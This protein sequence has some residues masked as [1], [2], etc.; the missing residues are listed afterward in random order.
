MELKNERYNGI[1][2]LRGISMILILVMHVLENLTYLNDVKN[3]ELVMARFG[4]L[5]SLFLM[6]SAF[7]CCCGYYQK[8]INGGMKEI[9]LFYSKRFKKIFPF[10]AFLTVIDVLLNF[11]KSA[12]IEGY[13]NITLIFG[14][15]PHENITTIGVG[16]TLGVIFIFYLLFPFFVYLIKNNYRLIIALFVTLIYTFV[17]AD[18]FQLGKVDFLF[19]AP[20]FV[21]GCCIYKIRQYII[22]YFKRL[23]VLLMIILLTML[24]YKYTLYRQYTRIVLFTFMLI[25]GIIVKNMTILDNKLMTFLSSISLEVY[26]SHMMI[27]RLIQKLGLEM[28]TSNPYINYI[29]ATCLTIG[30]TIIFSYG[31]QKI[32]IYTINKNKNGGFIK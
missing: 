32:Q 23:P 6:I 12:L 19:C 16:W 8:I 26:L 2:G 13:A 5:T 24:F 14:F 20:Y 11:S 30:G 10:F 9:E 1:N 29:I 28:L 22:K 7:S 18:Y 25:Y 4:D 31:F 27:F 21:I 3:L 15:I 17:C